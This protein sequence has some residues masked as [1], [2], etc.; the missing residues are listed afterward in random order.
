MKS[1]SKLIFSMLPFLLSAIC[2]GASVTLKVCDSVTGQALD[3]EVL[4]SYEEGELVAI[5]KGVDITSEL[6][7]GVYV[8]TVQANGYKPMTTWFGLTENQKHRVR[9][10]MD[11]I[12]PLEE[13]T[14]SYIAERK[15]E[16]QMI[17]HGFVTADESGDILS[18]VR[19]STNNGEQTI[20]DSRGYFYVTIPT[21]SYAAGSLQFEKNGFVI[22]KRE[23]IELW[24]GGDWMYRIA[25]QEGEGIERIDD[26]REAKKGEEQEECSDC[27]HDEENVT[28]SNSL[29]Q[30]N[31]PLRHTIRVGRNCTGTL[32]F[33][34]EVYTLDN[35]CELV[36]PHEWF[37]CWGSLS[38]GMNSLSAGAVAIRT[39]ASWHVNNPLNTTY[40][41]CDNTSC[42]FLG[43]T[44][45][46]NGNNAVAITSGYV[47][48]NGSTIARS[49]YSA[50][51]NN[52]G[53][54]NGFTG[55]GSSW[56]CIE[57]ALCVNQTKNGHG[58]GMCQWGSARWANGTR[59]STSSPC[60]PGPSGGL[61][62]KTWQEIL[63]HY[64]PPYT[65]V[66]G[67]QSSIQNVT[68][69]PN[70][71]NAG[72][73]FT[74]NYSVNASP[75]F[76]LMLG[77]SIAPTGTTNYTSDPAND[78]KVTVND[79]G[80]QVSRS[81]TVPAGTAPGFYDILTTVYY[82]TDNNNQI[83]NGDFRLDR[84][85]Y[86]LALTVGVTGIEQIDDIVPV[87]FSLEQ[88]YPNPFN[89]ATTF[90]FEVASR[91]Q[92]RLRIFDSLGKEIA[93]V[94]DQELA[95]G[96]YEANWNAGS[97]ASGIYFYRLE[98]T[99]E[100]GADFV[101]SRKLILSR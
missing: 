25:L 13:E 56:P 35:Y 12:E 8:V 85:R 78:N 28:A 36:L 61:G 46:T 58:R 49:E 50:E 3:A 99:S 4:I 26:S 32:C 59:L 17:L 2:F 80:N 101:E 63:D 24:Q 52:S 20:T 94:V 21:S 68:A 9:I 84:V 96:R 69:T 81:F 51:N 40:D 55:T 23:F 66:Q 5:E 16:E 42:Q 45:T 95:A 83:N 27:G 39:Y 19:V 43:S 41:I 38:G 54:G 62:T 44:T 88:N 37:S 15:N 33:D 74:L 10:F 72:G 76:Q 6:S 34:A 22:Q 75:S 57:D 18:G 65:L 11:R 86:T 31:P 92:V 1:F 97:I 93:R 87:A 91:S 7:S 100:S 14:S 89:P 79:G 64:Y 98:A 48:L 47:L 53:C 30:N 90:A 67:L 70:A 73:T 29:L 71:V 82:D 60:S 77:A